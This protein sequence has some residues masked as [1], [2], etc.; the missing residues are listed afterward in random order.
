MSE[1]LTSSVLTISQIAQLR[2]LF[3]TTYAQH[4]LNDSKLGLW[5][6]VYTALFNMITDVTTVAGPEGTSTTV[7]PKAGVDPQS[8]LWLRGARYINPV[9]R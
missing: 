6:P 7:Q 4:K 3:D 5:E 2:A 9:L 8:W 1:T